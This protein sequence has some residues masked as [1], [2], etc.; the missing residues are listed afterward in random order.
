MSQDNEEFYVE[1][2]GSHFRIISKAQKQESDE[3]NVVLF[4]WFIGAVVILFYFGFSPISFFLLI[5]TFIGAIFLRKIIV[6]FVGLFLLFAIG[7][8]IIQLFFG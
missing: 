1:Q 2:S 7:G 8:F 6:F 3:L 5:G 4:V